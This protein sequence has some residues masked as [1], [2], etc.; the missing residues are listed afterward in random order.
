MLV[1]I[2][3]GGSIIASPID[4]KRINQYVELL[5]QLSGDGHNVITVVGGGALARE[6]IRTGSTLGLSEE[7]QDWLAIHVSRLYALI[8]ALK[9]GEAGTGKVPTSV[10]E[11][12]NAL[13]ENRIVVMGGLRPG[14]TTDAVAAHV[15]QE[16]KAQL[17]VKATDQEGI[18][19]KDPR[20]YKDAKKLDKITFKKLARLLEQNRHKAGIHQI[21]DP[22]AVEILQKTRTRTIVVNGGNPR[23]LHAAVEGKKVGTVIAE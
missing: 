23:N 7:A 10:R 19:T 1:V 5:K 12:A 17:L 18:Y 14:M 4:P 15:A 11:A 16:V 3:L 2:R 9:L 21:L 6:L 20:K 8:L 13:K 22:V